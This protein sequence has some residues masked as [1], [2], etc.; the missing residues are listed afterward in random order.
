MR[1][2]EER[3]AANRDYQQAKD[4]LRSYKPKNWQEDDEYLRRNAAVESAEKRASWWQ[5]LK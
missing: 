1:R 2:N 4:R 5:Q 3:K